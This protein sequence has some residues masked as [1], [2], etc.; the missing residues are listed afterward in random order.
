MATADVRMEAT[1]RANDGGVLGR[2][3]A[4]LLARRERDY[5]LTHLLVEGGAY[6]RDALLPFDLI[7]ASSSQEV[8][9]RVGQEQARARAEADTPEGSIPMRRNDLVYA[10]DARLGQLRGVYVDESGKI[11]DL[12]INDE[13]ARQLSMTSIR[14]VDAIEPHRIQIG[15]RIGAMGELL[16]PPQAFYEPV[17]L[18][19][20]EELLHGA[21]GQHG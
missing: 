10:V 4:M 12:L 8:L 3:W 11:S 7:A 15:S 9:L 2:V 6:R 5:Y 18:R 16:K 14:S 20:E 19:S 21:H 17:E 13:V 1:V